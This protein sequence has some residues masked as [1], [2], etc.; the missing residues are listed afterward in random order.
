ALVTPGMDEGET[1]QPSGTAGDQSG[2]LVVG[3]VVIVVEQ[4]E[5]HGSVDAR[6]ARSP[7]IGAEWGIRIPGRR[8]GVPLARMAVEVDDHGTASAGAFGMTAHRDGRNGL[9]QC[10]FASACMN[11]MLVSIPLKKFGI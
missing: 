9:A 3:P 1:D 6:G 2:E 8:H 5:Y 11:Q 7:K 4:G 10:A